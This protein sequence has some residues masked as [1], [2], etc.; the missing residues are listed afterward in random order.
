M[1][2]LSSLT[3][4]VTVTGSVPR[5]CVFLGD[6]E[7]VCVYKYVQNLEGE[8]RFARAKWGKLAEVKLPHAPSVTTYYTSFVNC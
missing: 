8:Q 5:P 7:G 1:L 2:S 4:K 3:Q 6:M